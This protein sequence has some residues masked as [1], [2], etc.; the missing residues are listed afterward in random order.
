MK[1]FFIIFGIIRRVLII[2]A[3]GTL[4]GLPRVI[5]QQPYISWQNCYNPIHQYKIAICP[6]PG[7]VFTLRSGEQKSSV[8]FHGFLGYPDIEIIRFDS[9]GNKQWE[10][11]YGGSHY[12]FVIQMLEYSN[13]RY[14]V[15]GGARSTDGDVQSG[16]KGGFDIWLFAIDTTG[17]LL[18]EKTYGTAGDD[19]PVRV[20]KLPDGSLVVCANI[21]QQGGDVDTAYGDADMWF[22]RVDS[23]GNILWQKTLGAEGLNSC[24]DF[25][26][27]DKGNI[28]LTGTNVGD[29]FSGCYA[30]Q[31]QSIMLMEV[32]LEG[33]KLWNRCYGSWSPDYGGVVTQCQDGYVFAARV[34]GDG[35]YV[36]GYHHNPNT[37]QLYSDIWLVRTDWQGF[38]LWKKC[39]GG[40]NE[41]VPVSLIT[42]D[43]G[44]IYLFGKTRSDDYDVKRQL[45]SNGTNSEIWMVKCFS[46]GGLIYK[47]CFGGGEDEGLSMKSSVI[48]QNN[49]HFILAASA[50]SS[51][52]GDVACENLNPLP[53]MWL[54]KM[55]RCDEYEAGVP[56]QPEGDTAVFTLSEPETQYQIQP[57]ENNWRFDWQLEPPEAGR[58]TNLGLKARV[59]WQ[60]GYNGEALLRARAYSVCGYSEWTTP[61]KINVEEAYGITE[62]AIAGIKLY[63]NPASG[64]V[65]LQLPSCGPF[66]LTLRDISG[67]ILSTH[68]ATGG[69]HLWD[70]SGLQ[71]GMY[72]M[73]IS[74]PDGLS[75]RIKLLIAR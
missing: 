63:P 12:E 10:K 59:A 57:S 38:I 64:P 9:L 46:N 68:E 20:A 5:A 26:I 44:D 69:T 65:T 36:E 71:A 60:K 70:A 74:N 43:A 62:N 40:S 75:T 24:N 58:I 55:E 16:N 33:K 14:Y 15:L 4:W 47:R 7:G 17:S 13:D 35:E 6:Y 34:Y 23:L 8:V 18:W 27:N 37:S 52:S 56:G 2:T 50:L 21:Y 66:T 39:L 31:N 45:E 73:E 61:L 32:D 51:L 54:L 22:F 30:P 1:K 53:S 41:D 3:L 72:I 48:M 67:R 42:D 19:Y 49:R 25:I 28:V 29:Y 11:S